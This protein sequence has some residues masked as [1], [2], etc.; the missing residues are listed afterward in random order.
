MV[1]V[2]PEL[3]ISPLDIPSTV[4]VSIPTPPEEELTIGVN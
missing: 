3:I 4:K 1:L 2:S